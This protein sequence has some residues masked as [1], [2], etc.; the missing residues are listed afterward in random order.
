MV[1]TKEDGGQHGIGFLY[2]ADIASRMGGRLYVETSAPGRG[3]LIVLELR[4]CVIQSE[5]LH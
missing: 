5:R 2:S 1:T 3:T 4:E